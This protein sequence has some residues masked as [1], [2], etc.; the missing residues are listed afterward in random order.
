MEL[1]CLDKYFIE[2]KKVFDSL[3]HETM[4]KLMRYYGIPGKFISIIKTTY[5][6]MTCGVIYE[7]KTIDQLDVQTGV[8]QGS[9]CHH[10]C[11]W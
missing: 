8:R 9:I 3:D 5:K 11:S 2:Y 4:C 7:E 10:F 6:G 1:S